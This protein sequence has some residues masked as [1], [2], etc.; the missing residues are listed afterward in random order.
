ML[1]YIKNPFSLNYFYIRLYHK[2]NMLHPYKTELLNNLEKHFNEET[3]HIKGNFDGGKDEILLIVPTH[4]DLAPIYT[5]LYTIL[6][7][8]PEINQAPERTLISLCHPDGSGY[9]SRLINPNTQDE[10]HQALLGQL[11]SRR[12][13]SQELQH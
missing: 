1:Y 8:L 3:W 12:I 10:I 7:M 11:P 13:T 4:I 5:N 9:C 6:S 2:T